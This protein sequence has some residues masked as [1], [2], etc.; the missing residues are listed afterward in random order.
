M[1]K[2]I[3]IRFFKVYETENAD[4]KNAIPFLYRLFFWGNFKTI[5][6]KKT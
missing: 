4:I 5:I 2:S 1:S 6:E 3:W